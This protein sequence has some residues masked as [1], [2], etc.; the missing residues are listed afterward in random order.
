[1]RLNQNETIC[2]DRERRKSFLLLKYLAVKLTM[3]DNSLV[4]II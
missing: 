4:C 1:M 2:F 3:N